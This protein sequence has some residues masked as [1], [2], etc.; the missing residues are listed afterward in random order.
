MRLL[1]IIYSGLGGQG[2]FLFPLIKN[3]KKKN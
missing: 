1:H 3:L 2:E